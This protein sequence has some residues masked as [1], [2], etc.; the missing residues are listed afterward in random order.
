MIAREAAA[1]PTASQL[2]VGIMRGLLPDAKEA[3]DVV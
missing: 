2:E 3:V 1:V